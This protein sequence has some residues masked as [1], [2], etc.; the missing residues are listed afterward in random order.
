[1]EQNSSKGQFS[2]LFCMCGFSWMTGV[3]KHNTSCF[4]LFCVVWRWVKEGMVG[5]LVVHLLPVQ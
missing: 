1:M 4:A 2:S 3:L 5:V